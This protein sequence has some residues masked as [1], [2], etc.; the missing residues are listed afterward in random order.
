[1]FYTRLSSHG[2]IPK[3]Y[4]LSVPLI[5]KESRCFLYTVQFFSLV[6]STHFYYPFLIGHIVCYN[7][8]T[9]VY[10]AATNKGAHLSFNLI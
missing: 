8:L 9:I 3:N 2:L 5:K 7:F 6:S 4:P 1:M 10:Y